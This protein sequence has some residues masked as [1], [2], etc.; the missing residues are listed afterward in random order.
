[1]ICRAEMLEKHL[2]DVESKNSSQLWSRHFNRLLRLLADPREG[3]LA[4]C[5]VRYNILIHQ[6]AYLALP[7]DFHLLVACSQ[8]CQGASATLRFLA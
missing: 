2:P 6:T 3:L 7:F 8:R 5:G 1:M 4:L